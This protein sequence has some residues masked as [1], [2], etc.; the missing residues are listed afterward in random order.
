MVLTVTL[1]NIHESKRFKKGAF[2]F[3]GCLPVYQ[4]EAATNAGASMDQ[5]RKRTVEVHQ[6]GLHVVF[7]AIQELCAATPFRFADNKVHIAES[8]LAFFMGYQPAHD[9]HVAKKRKSC[10]LCGAPHDK[11][12]D[13][14]EVRPLIDWRARCCALLPLAWMT[15]EM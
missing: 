14:D 1:L 13:T 6:A 15:K 8:R 7:E 11:L 2:R 12:A 9:K 5:V 3:W 10:R 4:A